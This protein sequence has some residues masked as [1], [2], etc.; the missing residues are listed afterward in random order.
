MLRAKVNHEL[1]PSYEDAK[2]IYD[3]ATDILGED[4]YLLQQRAN[5][6]R[7]R[8]NGNLPLAQ[9][10]LEK[11]GQLESSDSTLVHTLAEILRALAEE[12][13]KRLERVR[14]R[15]EARAVLRSIALTAPAARYALVTE[16][17]L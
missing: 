3:A 5:Y 1:S 11:A 15:N 9:M 10:F 13:D 17:K 6:E 12:A 7:I 16:L 4:A 2:A 14:L 8:P